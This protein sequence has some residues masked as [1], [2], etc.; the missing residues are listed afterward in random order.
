M[1][2]TFLLSLLSA[3]LISACAPQPSIPPTLSAKDQ[4]I[5]ASAV[6]LTVLA[7]D[8]AAVENIPVIEASATP[9]PSLPVTIVT[10]GAPVLTL[11]PEAQ[12]SFTETAQA[13][14]TSSEDACKKILKISDAGPL[15]NVRLKNKTGGQ[16]RIGIHL[17]RENTYGQCGFL[18]NNPISIGKDQSYTVRLPEGA[19]FAWA[20]ITFKNG[21]TNPVYGNFTNSSSIGDSTIEIIIQKSGISG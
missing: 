7:K 1:K 8:T 16:I 4:N 19:Y 5:I 15:T 2:K 9:F 11:T 3:A 17:W 20:W 13:T 18:P 12:V 6:A 14:S 10:A 21:E